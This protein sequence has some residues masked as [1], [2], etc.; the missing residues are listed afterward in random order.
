MCEPLYN[1][2]GIQRYQNHQEPTLGN[3]TPNGQQDVRLNAAAARV[4]CER[5]VAHKATSQLLH[6]SA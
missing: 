4:R 1:P 5:H 2:H 3:T 6:Q